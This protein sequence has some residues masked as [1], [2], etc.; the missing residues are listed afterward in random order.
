M[1]REAEKKL[2]ERVLAYLLLF[3]KEPSKLPERLKELLQQSTSMAKG[4]NVKEMGKYAADLLKKAAEE[5][6]GLA[7]QHTA[8]FCQDWLEG[9]VLKVTFMGLSLEDTGKQQ[10]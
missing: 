5:G 4:A 8:C 9:V 2:A 10:K 1:I 6:K 3:N 7:V